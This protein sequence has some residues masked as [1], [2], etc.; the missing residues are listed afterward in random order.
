MKKLFLLIP[1]F[2]LLGFDY[3]YKKTD[4]LPVQLRDELQAEIPEIEGV[5]VMKSQE[6]MIIHCNK[7]LSVSEKTIIDNVV[8]NHNAKDINTY[9][10][11]KKTTEN[12]ILRQNIL[13]A[14]SLD[15]LKQIIIDLLIK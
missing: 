8:A 13:D 5:T 14:G 1:L 11:D 10:L 3:N 15:E 6:K 4:V 12:E 2:F 7:E 9:I